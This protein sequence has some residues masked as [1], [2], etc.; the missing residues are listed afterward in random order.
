VVKLENKHAGP[1]DHWR[2]AHS[3]AEADAVNEWW[4]ASPYSK[5]PGHRLFI[6]HSPLPPKDPNL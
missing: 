6:I 1:K 5:L 2:F 3:K 4:Q